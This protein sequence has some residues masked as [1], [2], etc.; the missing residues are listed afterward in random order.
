MSIDGSNERQLLADPAV[1]DFY[2]YGN[3]IYFRTLENGENKLYTM[4][5]DGS[6]KQLLRDDVTSYILVD[7]WIYYMQDQKLL[8]KMS[9]DGSTD[10]TL[11]EFETPRASIKTYHRGWLYV[12]V[13]V[14]G[15]IAASNP[16]ERVRIDGTGREKVAEARPLALYIAG[17]EMY[18]TNWV[19]GDRVMEHFK[20]GK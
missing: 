17:E 8:H 4:N 6:G 16:I 20:L 9:L 5:A 10:I 11:N 3:Q 7:D 18:F 12:T 13:A 19:M 1:L 2:L 14:S 15:S